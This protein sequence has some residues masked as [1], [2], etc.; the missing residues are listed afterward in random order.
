MVH[1]F[2]AKEMTCWAS[3]KRTELSGSKAKPAALLASVMRGF[4]MVITFLV[5]KG[6]PP[7]LEASSVMRN[8]CWHVS[9]SPS[10][11]QGSPAWHGGARTKINSSSVLSSDDSR[12]PDSAGKC[13]KS[14]I[15]GLFVDLKHPGL[16]KTRTLRF[17]SV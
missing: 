15:V 1:V 8:F 2:V 3:S 6:S 9:W 16:S 13:C 11:Q 4:K 12:R 7:V 5:S 14:D 17:I 10:H